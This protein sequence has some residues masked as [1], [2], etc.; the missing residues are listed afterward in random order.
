MPPPGTLS[1]R[2]LR[3]PAED[4]AAAEL[5][6]DAFLD[7]P[8]MRVLVGHDEGARSRLRRL[9]VMEFGPSSHVEA[10]AAELDGRIVGAL[11]YIDAPDCSSVSAGRVISFM[12]IAGPR[13]VRAMRMF[14]RIERAHP[15]SAHRHLPSVG[16]SPGAQSR[17]VGKA[18][19]DA[20]HERCDRD[21]KTSYLETIR[22]SDPA[23]PSLERF[24]GRLG[25]VVADVVPMT[26]EWQALTMTRSLPPGGTTS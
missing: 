15:K 13:V 12:R 16:V 5:L 4:E 17:G 23:K 1:V 2:D 3:R 21:G 20:F 14:A 26:E 18:L 11:T 24:Y 8:A 25:Y 22:W 10:L 9:F 6:T 19:M 7:F